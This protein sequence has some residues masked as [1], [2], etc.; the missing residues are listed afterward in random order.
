MQ[1]FCR[2]T[3]LSLFVALFLLVSG[4]KYEAPLA[5]EHSIPIDPA[6]LGVWEAIPEGDEKPD[7]EQRIVIL[8]YSDTEYLVHYPAAG[9]GTIYWRAYPIRVGD[10]AC[11]QLQALGTGQGM[12]APSEKDLFHVVTYRL[13]GEKLAIRVLDS[14]VVDDDIKETAAL[15]AAFVQAKNREDLFDEPGLFKKVPP[16]AKP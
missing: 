12:I 11:V 1:A 13:E 9:K 2:P 14:D 5:V 4:C 3:F 16:P 10:V 7:P 15:Q 8:R 6:L